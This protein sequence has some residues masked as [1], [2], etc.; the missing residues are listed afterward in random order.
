MFFVKYCVVKVVF[1]YFCQISLEG[2]MYFSQILTSSQMPS[3]QSGLKVNIQGMSHQTDKSLI[4][5]YRLTFLIMTFI[6]LTIFFFPTPSI[7][8]NM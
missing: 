1:G 3:Y 2:G 7:L 5:F 4:H 6:R 8:K